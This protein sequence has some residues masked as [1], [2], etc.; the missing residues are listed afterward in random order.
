MSNKS[1][2]Y[3]ILSFCFPTTEAKYKIL[4]IIIMYPTEM[5]APRRLETSV[6][7]FYTSKGAQWKMTTDQMA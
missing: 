4:C 2:I 5:I 3:Q 1:K 6:N 7:H